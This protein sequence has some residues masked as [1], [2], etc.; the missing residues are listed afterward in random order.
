[1]ES[2]FNPVGMEPHSVNVDTNFTD[3]DVVMGQTYYYRLSA[4]DFSENESEFSQEA[5]AVIAVVGVE[6]EGAGLPIEYSL[7]QNYP[8][9]FNPETTI[10]YALPEASRVS[11]VVYNLQGEEVAR[12]IDNVQS[13][14]NY[15]TIWN[16]SNVTSGVYIYRLQAGSFVQT[17]KMI[18]MK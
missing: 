1:M 3:T 6:N 15:S 18:L 14:G 17:K 8:N 9:P 13:A 2:G 12:L 4:F 5:S 11:I 7:S 10:R 16:T